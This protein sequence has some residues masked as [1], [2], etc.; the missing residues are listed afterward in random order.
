MDNKPRRDIA[1]GCRRNTGVVDVLPGRYGGRTSQTRTTGTSPGVGV[2]GGGV[3]RRIRLRPR[4]RAADGFCQ[5]AGKYFSYWRR[6]CNGETSETLSELHGLLSRSSGSAVGPEELPADGRK[7]YKLPAIMFPIRRVC[8]RVRRVD[9]AG[10]AIFRPS[11]KSFGSVFPKN[12][13]VKRQRPG[14]F[15]K[16]CNLHINIY[17]YN[18]GTGAD[19]FSPK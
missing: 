18:N 16:L 17:I 6:P 2:C 7:R 15:T 12:L 11:D 10:N 14:S 9:I 19:D 3:P 1:A 13:F 5:M 4:R 8:R